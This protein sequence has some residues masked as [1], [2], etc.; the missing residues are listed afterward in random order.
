[1][2]LKKRLVTLGLALTMAVASC[3]V[4][5]AASKDVELTD[6]TMAYYESSYSNHSA[7]AS[8]SIYSNDTYN[9]TRV[10][11]SA[12]V[13]AVNPNNGTPYAYDSASDIDD[14]IAEVD[15]SSS[16]HL[17]CDI[18]SY[19]YSYVELIGGFGYS[20]SDYLQ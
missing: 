13:Y 7:Y 17:I 5:T 20:D 19:H 3:I 14:T 10:E 4:V 6:N 11:V 9:V 1:M 15:F 12:T 18:T 2:T 16:S 8:T